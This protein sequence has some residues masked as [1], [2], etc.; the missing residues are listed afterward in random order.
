MYKLVVLLKN[1]DFHILI[2]FN[3]WISS[4]ISRIDIA[5]LI[6][7]LNYIEPDVTCHFLIDRGTGN[8]KTPFMHGA[9]VIYNISRVI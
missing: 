4:L 3:L 1:R 9:L 7:R 5:D 6:Q 8:I 2:S